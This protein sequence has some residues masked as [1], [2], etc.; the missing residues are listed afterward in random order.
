MKKYK[1]F[2]ILLTLL[3]SLILTSCSP[4][5]EIR[6]LAGESG[7]IMELLFGFRDEG[8]DSV[9]SQAAVRGAAS[10]PILEA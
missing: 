10:Q 2:I 5:R 4:A 6:L 8:G 7:E 9:T 1:V 3:S